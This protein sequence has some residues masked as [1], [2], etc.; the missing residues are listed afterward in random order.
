MAGRNPL[1]VFGLLIIAAMLVCALAAPLMLRR[2]AVQLPQRLQAI[3]RTGWH[4]RDEL[5]RII[6][7]AHLRGGS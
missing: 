3:N 2:T 6:Y 5:S 1:T 4:R 7:G